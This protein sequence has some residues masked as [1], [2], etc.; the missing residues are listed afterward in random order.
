MSLSTGTGPLAGSPAGAFNFDVAAASPA[1]RIYWADEQRRLR[2]F[3]DGVVLLDTTRAKLLHETGIRPRIYAPMEDYAADLLMPTETRTHCP[4]K[5]DASYWTV[6]VGD[7]VLDD[8]LW[9]YRDPLPEASWL[10]GH[11]ALYAD[12]VSE[13]LV[14]DDRM[15]GHL[16]DPFHRVDVHDSSRRAVARVGG[17]EVACSPHPKLL[18]ETSIPVRVYFPLRDVDLA[19]VGPG[20]G[21]RTTCAYKGEATYWTVAGV[22]DAAWSYEAPLGEVVR[23]QGHLCFDTR[24]E[25]VEVELGY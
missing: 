23:A 6:T 7:T 25:G 20:S 21:R 5:G 1:H 14:E 9:A 12:R 15:F 22:P 19:V 4:F 10:A 17:V 13:W 11:A 16:R 8:V 2:A 3:V 24:V 18:F